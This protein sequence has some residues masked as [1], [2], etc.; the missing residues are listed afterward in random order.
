MNDILKWRRLKFFLRRIGFWNAVFEEKSCK[1]K[2]I[3][4]RSSI[5]VRFSKIWA[6]SQWKKILNT[7]ANM[8]N[9]DETR[10]TSLTFSS[11]TVK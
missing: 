8:W 3:C 10:R 9:F 4:H 1:G 7:S 5:F 2:M 6:V 11:W